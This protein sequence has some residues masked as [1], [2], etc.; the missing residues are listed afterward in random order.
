MPYG[1]LQIIRR[2]IVVIARVMAIVGCPFFF[3][4]SSEMKKMNGFLQ[5]DVILGW[6]WL[7]LVWSLKF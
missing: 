2:P 6:E 3:S 7:F 4:W 1:R 5:N